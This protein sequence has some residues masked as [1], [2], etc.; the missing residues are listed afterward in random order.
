MVPDLH[1]FSGRGAKDT[2]PLYRT[3]DTSAPNV[4]PG[5]LKALSE[6]L[7][8][9]VTP[10]DLVAYFYGTLAQPTFCRRF[11]EFLVA[12]A[13]R[14]PITKDPALFGKL[15]SLGAKLIYLHTYGER[16]VSS[17]ERSGQIPPGTAKCLEAVPSG[18]DSYPQSF[19]Y[20]AETAVLQV[21]SGRFAP[22]QREVFEFAVS[23]L[24]VVKSWLGYR[25]KSGR[26][27]K[28]SPLNN[29]RPTSWTAAF[30]TELL[31]LLWVLEATVAMYPHQAKLLERVVTGECLEARDLPAVPPKLRRPPAPAKTDRL[32]L[33]Q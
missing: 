23:G 28:S 27:R 26:G 22:V 3:A 8:T 24:H 5:L 1:H 15:R 2:I 18:T 4:L 14:V 25:V 9:S 29:I 31:D 11:S 16:F 32:V 30:T 33:G 12:R 19:L 21:G 7:Q 10:E 13:L 6:A 17:S 20:D